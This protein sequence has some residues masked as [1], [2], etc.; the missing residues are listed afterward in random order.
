M[1][2]DDPRTDE[3][4]RKRID[5]A[6]EAAMPKYRSGPGPNA[7]AP[8]GDSVEIIDRTRGSR[9]RHAALRVRASARFVEAAQIAAR[10]DG[11]GFKPLALADWVG[12][13]LT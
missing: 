12:V 13:D 11:R 4:A 8:A 3:P 9:G 5:R 2:E 7:T 10:R 6:I 1:G